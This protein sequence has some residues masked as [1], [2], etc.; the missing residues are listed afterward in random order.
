MPKAYSRDR[1]EIKEF[2]MYYL[3]GNFKG[4][5]AVQS[6]RV[7]KESN[8]PDVNCPALRFKNDSI[9]TLS[10]IWVANP[11]DEINTNVINILF[12][13]YLFMWRL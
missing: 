10:A 12:D 7:L 3:T 8:Y 1:I 6:N 13:E 11:N 2:M 9:R 5:Y 4:V